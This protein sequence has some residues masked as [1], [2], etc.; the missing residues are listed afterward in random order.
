M[1]RCDWCEGNNL[2]IEYHDKEWGVPVYEDRIHFEFLLLESM[3]SGLS[4]QT[5]LM[6]RENFRAAFDQFDYNLI[7]QYDELKIAAL[8]KNEGIIRYRKKIESVIN[9]AH[10]FIAIQKEFG[11]FNQYIWQFT[12]RKII[13]NRYQ[14]SKEV[15]SKTEL[16]DLISYDLKKKGFKF[17]GSIT[18]YA[19]LQAV[20]II[21]NHLD[22]CFKKV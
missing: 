1:K 22:S 21:D 12:N 2:Q 9:N 10:A 8:L 16:S 3:Q 13:V 20:G 6:K 18:V 5:I 15:P 4:W 14:A 11:S 19:Y 7:A 17:L